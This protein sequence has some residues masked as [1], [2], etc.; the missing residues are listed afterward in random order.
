MARVA[1]IATNPSIELE[2]A[3]EVDAPAF[4]LPNSLQL[5]HITRWLAFTNAV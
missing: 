1:R 5:I 2:V 4:A 3:A